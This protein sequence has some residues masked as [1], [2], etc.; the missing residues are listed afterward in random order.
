MSVTVIYSDCKAKASGDYSA[1]A[2]VAY[3][4]QNYY[5]KIGEDMHCILASSPDGVKKFES[6]YGSHDGLSH[7]DI[8]GMPFEVVKLNEFAY[9]QRKKD[10]SQYIEVAYCDPAPLD[11]VAKIVNPLSTKVLMVGLPHYPIGWTD[12][13]KSRFPQSCANGLAHAVT[14]GFGPDRIGVPL[15]QGP[16]EPIKHENYAGITKKPYGFAYF[17]GGWEKSDATIKDYLAISTQLQTPYQ[18]FVFVGDCKLNLDAIKKFAIHSFKKIEVCDL[19]TQT[20]YNIAFNRNSSHLD[21]S[22]HP[23]SPDYDVSNQDDETIHI[24]LLEKVPNA[25]MRSLL[26]YAQPFIC[27]EGINTPIEAMSFGKIPFIQHMF[28]NKNFYPLYKK[29]FLDD[30]QIS[31]PSLYREMSDMLK[32]CIRKKPMNSFERMYLKRLLDDPK[33]AQRYMET[34]LQLTMKAPNPAERMVEELKAPSSSNPNYQGKTFNEN[35]DPRL[36]NEY[37]SLLTTLLG[38]INRPTRSPHIQHSL[39]NSKNKDHRLSASQFPLQNEFEYD[40]PTQL[41]F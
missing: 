4:L 29:A 33:L 15:Y 40:W 5:Y 12:E 26:K 10:V 20:I 31:S 2:E 32:L 13:L 37:F 38:A 18:H 28:N 22:K 19:S 39:F 23:L 41:R 11:Q 6:L 7:L 30:C 36:L 34:N 9:D 21:I 27:T 24:C 1:A 8:H 14:T 17:K 25:Q 16:F 35:H 3:A